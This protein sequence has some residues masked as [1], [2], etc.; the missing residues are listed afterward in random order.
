MVPK[1]L[2]ARLYATA[3]F[4]HYNKGNLIQLG[5]LLQHRHNASIFSFKLFTSSIA[6]DRNNH[7]SDTFTMSYLINSCGVTPELA[8]KLSTRVHLKNPKAPNAVLH[9]LKN[10]G[11]SKAHVT[12]LV[13]KEPLVLTA[14]PKATL[15]PKFNFLRSIGVSNTDM[16][17]IIV[18]NHLILLRSLEKCLIPRYEVLRS[19]VRDN[20]EVV[21]AL[22]SSA[23]GFTYC[24]IMTHLVPNIEVL[25][26][27]G[28]PQSS[29]SLLMVNFAGIAYVKHSKF[30]EAVKMVEEIGFDPLKTTFVMAVQVLIS[31]SKEGWEGRLVFYEKWG[32]NHNMALQAFRTFPNFM[33]LSEESVMKK[34]SFL[35]KDMGF[36]SEEVAESPQVLAYN[37]EKRMIPRFSVIK[38][39]KSKGL[40]RK[41]LRI[42]SLLNLTDENFLKKFVIKFQQ[43]LPILPDVYKGLI[44]HNNVQLRGMG[45]ESH[46]RS[47]VFEGCLYDMYETVLSDIVSKD[48]VDTS[49]KPCA[50]NWSLKLKLLSFLI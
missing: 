46:I 6:S 28:V 45:F 11:F 42:V 36:P 48:P 47:E 5:S 34:M 33:K 4:T 29:I 43:D 13:E 25:R 9:L 27:C 39:L 18:G 44:N 19:V 26:Q 16:P 20:L 21:R 14:R 10:Y 30:V 32:W 37:L 35:V 24:D 22:K 1:F 40:L 7:K 50:Q 15:L 23:R 3:S 41:K 49:R 8:K 12:K 38:I 31:T 17:K 2:I